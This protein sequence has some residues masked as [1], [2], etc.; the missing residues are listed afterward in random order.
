MIVGQLHAACRVVSQEVPP[1]LEAARNFTT[2]EWKAMTLTPPPHK[3][4]AV[5]RP[6]I[7]GKNY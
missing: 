5:L 4:I 2:L 7:T 1:Y 6:F 3:A